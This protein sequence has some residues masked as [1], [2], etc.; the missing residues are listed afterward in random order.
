[1]KGAQLTSEAGRA[2]AWDILRITVLPIVLSIAVGVITALVS[3]SVGLG[4]IAALLVGA[5]AIL[6]HLVITL[7]RADAEAQATL[8]LLEPVTTAQMVDRSTGEYLLSLA[9]AQVT[10]LTTARELPPVF[11]LELAHQREVLLDQYKESAHGRIRVNLRASPV[12]RETEGVSSV[13]ETLHATSAV[14]PLT[15][16]DVPGGLSYLNQQEAML[17]AGVSIKRVFIHREANLPELARVIA[18]HLEWRHRYGAEKLDV[19]VTLIDDTLDSELVMDFA[20]VDDATV[21]GLETHHG[22]AQPTAIVWEAAPAAVTQAN[23]R[24]ERLWTVGLDP[25]T[26][27]PFRA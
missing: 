21:I 9:K 12:L 18:T 3:V 1:M 24:F 7:Q 10:F 11:D 4:V 5:I 2:R 20:V 25:E 14:P 13:R 6:V 19:R 22:I 16:W 26:L 23:R 27:A 8:H 17:E 15:Y